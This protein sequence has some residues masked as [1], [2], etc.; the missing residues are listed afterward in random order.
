MILDWSPVLSA[1]VE[2]ASPPGSSPSQATKDVLVAIVS[3]GTCRGLD[4]RKLVIGFPE[5]VW[6]TVSVPAM[7]E[8]VRLSS[9]LLAALRH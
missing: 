9:R 7:L 2:R 4:N 8:V 3:L 6:G 5:L 1:V